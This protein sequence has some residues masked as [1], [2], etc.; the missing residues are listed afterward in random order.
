MM[1]AFHLLISFLRWYVEAIRN[2]T[3]NGFAKTIMIWSLSGLTAIAITA[4]LNIPTKWGTISLVFG[5]GGTTLCVSLFVVS[6][7]ML[8]YSEY[9]DRKNADDS[10][11]IKIRHMGLI[12]HS[13][14]DV[15]NYMPR[16]LKRIK[17]QPFDIEF[18]NSHKT[19]EID[20]LNKQLSQICRLPQTIKDS[21]HS[22]NNGKKYIVYSGVAP[23]PMVAAAG[24][25]ISNMQN[26][27]VADWNREEKKWHF[28]DELDDGEKLKFES[29]G[30]GDKCIDSLNIAV[31]FSLPIR[32]QNIEREFPNS[33]FYNI[34]FE[35]GTYGYDKICSKNKQVRL[36]KIILEFINN[37]VIPDY[38][39]LKRI[40]FFVAAQASFVFQLGS[41]LNQGHLPSVVFHHYNPKLD[42]K[43]HPWGI[44]FNHDLGYKV[45]EKTS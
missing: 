18:G 4:N 25:I 1:R 40:D 23:V 22:I 14:D 44:A 7:L 35:S 38:Q 20:E 36:A 15:Q 42:M 17:P 13:I 27:H 8:F 29:V 31:S 16:S 28:N 30:N 12:N 3:M 41:V 5:G 21:G 19:T 37:D 45:V 43:T 2:P 32:L 10:Q 11:L 34:M 26:V 9:Q 24:H 39:N 33:R 6:L